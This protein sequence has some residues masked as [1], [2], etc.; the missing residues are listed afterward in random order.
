[1]IKLVLT[2]MDD[3]LI[4]AGA[5][6]VSAR[7]IDAIHVAQKAGVH[8]GPVSGRQPDA[9]EWMFPQNPECYAT[10]AFCNGQVMIVDGDV[11]D[12]KALDND[13]LMRLAT[14]LEEETD[15]TFLKVYDLGA[16]LRSSV[17]Y[18]VTDDRARVDAAMGSGSNAWLNEQAP[19]RFAIDDMP[20]YKA[21]IWSTRTTEELAQ[22]RERMN[23]V[24][25]ELEYVF[26][27]NQARLFDILPAGWNKG[28]AVTAIA[29]TL[30]VGMDEIA[31]FGD[32]DNDLPMIQAVPNAVAMGNAN[33]HVRSAARWHIGNATDEAEADA[34]LDIARAAVA[35]TM[36]AFMNA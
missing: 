32:S 8:F 25:P 18:C 7:A 19:S 28:C 31:V 24:A 26:P 34:L 12:A 4:P 33:D 2:D 10:G 22:L 21:N 29:K 20:Y 36:P 5:P 14:F 9:M 1:M 27:N 35:G 23:E 3:T 11:V 17:S 13:A 15:D 16:D 30:G 6:R